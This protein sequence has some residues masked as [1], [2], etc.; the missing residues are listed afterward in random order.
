MIDA[1]YRFT[2]DTL[3]LVMFFYSHFS[4]PSEFQKCCSILLHSYLCHS[5]NSLFQTRYTSENLLLKHKIQGIQ[6]H[7]Y[8]VIVFPNGTVPT[9][10]EVIFRDSS[11]G[12]KFT[13][14]EQA[15]SIAGM[16]GLN[17]ETFYSPCIMY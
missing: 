15:N 14:R 13:P 1:Y 9:Q 2:Q 16:A 3:T 5:S 8:W 17:I 7:L 12:L 6:L 4:F 10:D 11:L